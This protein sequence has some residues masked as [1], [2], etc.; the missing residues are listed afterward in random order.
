MRAVWKYDAV[1]K[2]VLAMLVAMIGLSGIIVQSKEAAACD[3]TG[4]I[5][6]PRPDS[7]VF[8]G[9]VLEIR[10]DGHVGKDVAFEVYEVEQGNVKALT[11]AWTPY[12]TYSCGGFNFKV[13][14]TYYVITIDSKIFPSTN[15]VFSNT[16]RPLLPGE[17]GRKETVEGQALLAEFQKRSAVSVSIHAEAVIADRPDDSC[18]ANKDN[19]VMVPLTGSFMSRFG[20]EVS[21]TNANDDS[22]T[23]DY[24]GSAY[25]YRVGQNTVHNGD[26]QFLMDTVIERYDG[27]T[28]IPARQVAAIVDASLS[29]N[30]ER[31]AMNFYF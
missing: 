31:K 14:E 8:I 7:N 17:K 24:K 23:L 12:A 28:F 22:V 27:V 26:N 13:G 1:R 3:Y 21:Q 30:N 18:Y 25:T 5:I 6:D 9:K 15:E 10:D 16:A 19:R 4:T 11:K 20:I 2:S 29:W